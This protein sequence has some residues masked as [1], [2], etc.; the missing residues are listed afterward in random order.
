M[1]ASSYMNLTLLYTTENIADETRLKD[2]FSVFLLMR[3]AAPTHITPIILCLNISNSSFL[4]ELSHINIL[5]LFMHLI[6][7]IAQEIASVL[8]FIVRVIIE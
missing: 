1:L 5:E 7:Q 2:A 6:K 8:L 4:V 3:L